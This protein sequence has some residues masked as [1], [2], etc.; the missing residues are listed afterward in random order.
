MNRKIQVMEKERKFFIK[1]LKK[2]GNWDKEFIIYQWFEKSEKEESVKLKIIFD[3][4]NVRQIAVRVTKRKLNAQESDKEIEYLNVEEID[5]KAY[6]GVNFIAKRRAIFQNIFLDRFYRSDKA[7]EFLLEIED[8][9]NMEV[10]T[11]LGV[12]PGEEVTEKLAYSNANMSVPFL[13]EDYQALNILLNT[14]P[15]WK[16]Q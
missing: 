8:E 13:E 12:Q 16:V 7:C 2:T 14:I 4:C 5:F 15:G 1:E 10:L 3:L 9:M 11:A 6:L